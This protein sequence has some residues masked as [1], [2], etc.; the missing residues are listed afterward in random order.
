[1][2]FHFWLRVLFTNG[3][4]LLLIFPYQ[5]N[6]IAEE[7]TG[8]PES[9]QTTTTKHFF[10]G[11]NEFCRCYDPLQDMLPKTCSILES[12]CSLWE[13]HGKEALN[14]QAKEGSR[15]LYFK[16]DDD[17]SN[18]GEGKGSIISGKEDEVVA[19]WIM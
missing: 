19:K 7:V 15:L 14:L 9:S 2:R 10:I 12:V 5:W 17:N 1:M 4:G 6:R 3:N 11:W 18:N 13:L 8:I 16:R